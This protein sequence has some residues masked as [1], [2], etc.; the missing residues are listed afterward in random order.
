MSPE[1]LAFKLGVKQLF[2]QNLRPDLSLYIYFVPGEKAIPAWHELR[3]LAP[4]LGYWPLVLGDDRTF[5]LTKKSFE[6]SAKSAAKPSPPS[7]VSS[8]QKFFESRAEEVGDDLP[9]GP[10]PVK[11]LP[12]HSFYLPGEREKRTVMGLIPA[13]HSVQVLQ[14]LNYGGWNECPLVHEHVAV[15]NYWDKRYGAEIVCLSSDILEL[16]VNHRPAIREE[17]LALAK[18]QYFYCSDIV[19][20]G[21][22]TIQALAA[23]LMASDAWFFWWD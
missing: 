13:S 6:S 19:E 15:H 5:E 14:V 2:E 20:Q 3:K 18:E 8:A 23:G 16:K 17:A 1:E 12:A 22:G 7:P 10:W 9:T 21:T 11:E 4:G